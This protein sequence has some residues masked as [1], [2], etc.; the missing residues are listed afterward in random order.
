MRFAWNVK[1]N[2]RKNARVSQK[3]VK[4][5]EEWR[6]QL[7]DDA[8][9]VSRLGGTEPAFSGELLDNKAAGK[10]VC[11][12]CGAELFSSDTKYDSGSGWPSFFRALEGNNVTERVDNTHGMARTEILCSKCDGHLGH[13]FPDGPKPTG[14]RYCTNSL[15]LD[16]KPAKDDK[17]DNA[18]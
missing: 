14:L 15:S 16:F 7:G 12:S 4:S 13:V 8:Y 6:A 11:V 9:Q 18:D 3:T 5:E 2:N 10:Y 17:K 1:R